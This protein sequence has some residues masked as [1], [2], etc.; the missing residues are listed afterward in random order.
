MTLKNPD[1][2]SRFLLSSSVPDSIVR[3]RAKF[4]ERNSGREGISTSDRVV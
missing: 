2:L 4:T 3:S 1:S